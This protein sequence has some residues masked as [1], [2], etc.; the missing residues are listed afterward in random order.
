MTTGRPWEWIWCVS[1]G[2]LSL[3]IAVLAWPSV[4]Q[5]QQNGLCFSVVVSGSAGRQYKHIWSQQDSL[6]TILLTPG[7]SSLTNSAL[8]YCPSITNKGLSV[9]SSGLC[10]E[11]LIVPL[12]LSHHLLLRALTKTF[13]SII[14][15]SLW[16]LLLQWI[17]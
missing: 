1:L 9:T 5:E 10:T 14:S 8:L 15:L 13:S 4:E 17:L 6:M 7:Y 3:L 12:D 2:P 11:P 16:L